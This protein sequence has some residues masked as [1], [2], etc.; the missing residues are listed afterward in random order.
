MGAT[1]CVTGGVNWAA[2]AVSGACLASR[3][4]T[5]GN[6]DLPS[7]DNKVWWHNDTR[8]GRCTGAVSSSWPPWAATVMHKATHGPDART[9]RVPCGI[10]CGRNAEWLEPLGKL[11]SLPPECREPNQGLCRRWAHIED[12]NSSLLPDSCEMQWTNILKKKIN[13]CILH[14][15]Y[16]SV[17]QIEQTCL[18]CFPIWPSYIS[19]TF[20]WSL[21]PISHRSLKCRGTSLLCEGDEGLMH[22]YCCMAT[23]SQVWL[24]HGKETGAQLIWLLHLEVISHMLPKSAYSHLPKRFCSG[25]SRMMEEL[26]WVEAQS[27]IF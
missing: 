5:K 7:L 22:G 2:A 26:N 1:D 13:A 14:S 6:V 24:T 16:T 19:I 12:V 15:Y 8:A 18:C 20:T 4:R 21:I 11:S 17:A 23:P 27:D 9:P 3:E 10:R 25:C